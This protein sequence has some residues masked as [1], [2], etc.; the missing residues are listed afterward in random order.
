MNRVP[1]ED[2]EHI[3][4]NTQD[5]W[6]SFRGKSIF[7][8]GGTGF[9]G[10]W[11]LESFIY[12]NDKLELNSKITI[13]TRNPES[14]LNHFP[15][16]SNYGKTVTFVKGDILTYDFNLAEKFNYVI[17][18]A[19][20]ASESLNISDP[21]LMMDTITI[22][23]RK[24]LE[25]AKTQP[26]EGFLFISSGAIYGKQPSSVAQIEESDSFKID[27]NKSSSAYSEGKRVAELYCSI[28]YEKYKLPLK[29]ARCFAFVGPYLP[30]DTHFA[31]GNFINNVLKDHDIIIKGDG[32]TVRTYMYASDLAI[33]LW[34]ILNDGMPNEAY[35][36]GSDNKITI[37]KLGEIILKLNNSKKKLIILNEKIDSNLINIYVPN[38]NKLK[39]IKIWNNVSL[40]KSILKTIKFHTSK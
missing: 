20:A 4:E 36:V 15:F 13:L 21:L 9:F 27:I 24:V 25:F 17:H 26:I 1:V 23:T 2:L 5:I 33:S 28:F 40:E 18:A 16:Y 29:I 14:F 8:T 37:K 31:I 35:N 32:S 19:T 6:E 30:L 38:I 11:L 34:R 22:G 3:Y 10:K 12:I 7:L 39:K